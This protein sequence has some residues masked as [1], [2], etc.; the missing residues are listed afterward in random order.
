MKAIDAS[1][2]DVVAVIAHRPESSTA[3]SSGNTVASGSP[4]LIAYVVMSW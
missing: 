2:S 1:G 4:W 3:P